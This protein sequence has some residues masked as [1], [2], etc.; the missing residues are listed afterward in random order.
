MDNQFLNLVA[1]AGFFGFVAGVVITWTIARMVFPGRA[2]TVRDHIGSQGIGQLRRLAD[3]QARQAQ[4]LAEAGKLA[5][6]AYSEMTKA[7]E[8][9]RQA[10]TGLKTNAE[11]LSSLAA[12]PGSGP[13]ILESEP[14]RARTARA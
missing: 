8:L 14:L 2:D 1:F 4:V 10:E 3:A 12:G 9:L 6:S 5:Q 11:Q 13:T 7:A